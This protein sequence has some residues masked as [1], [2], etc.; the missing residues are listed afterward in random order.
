MENLY[1]PWRNKYSQ[2]NKKHKLSDEC[3]FC[4]KIG[5]P[6]ENDTKNFILKRGKHNFIIM[7]LYPYN[8]GHLMVIP[9]RHTPKLEDLEREEKAEFTDFIIECTQALEKGLGAQGINVGMNIGKVAGAGIPQHIHMH[10]VPRW[11]GDTN[12]LPVIG[13]V[14]QISFDMNDIYQKIKNVL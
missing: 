12:F 10:L 11:E 7:N 9:N 5:E 13:E 14:K 8:P 3:P 2:G 6:A 1:A 4:A